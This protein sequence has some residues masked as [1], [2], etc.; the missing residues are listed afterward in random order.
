[1]F[2]THKNRRHVRG[3]RDT[4]RKQGVWVS[5][6]ENLTIAQALVNTLNEKEP[7]QWMDGDQRPVSPALPSRQ[8]Q[9]TTIQ[10]RTDFGREIGNLAKMYQDENK[11]SGSSDSFKYKVVIF[12][13]CCARVSIPDEA[14]AKAFPTMLKDMA[15]DYFYSTLFPNKNL[16]FHQ[17]CEGMYEYFEGKQHT[18]DSL[19]RW[20]AL[21]LPSVIS[22]N[23][24][25][26]IEEC[27]QILL[28]ELR[29]LQRSLDPSMQVDPFIHNKLVTACETLPA[30]FIVCFRPPP[31]VAELVGELKS[32][33]ITYNKS[34]PTKNETFFTDRRFHKF[35]D[36]KR[37]NY[38]THG[39]NTKKCYVCGKEGCFSTKHSREDQEESKKQW[40]ERWKERS[41]K[42][43]DQY[44]TEYEGLDEKED[45]GLDEAMKGLTFD[46]SDGDH[47]SFITTFGN[48][49][50]PKELTQTLANNSFEHFL[51]GAI[52]NTQD[53][54]KEDF[55]TP[56]VTVQSY[57]MKNSQ[58][59][60][61]V[62]LQTSSVTVQRYCATDRYNPSR[63]HGIVIDT[64]ASRFSTAGK[65]QY[66]AYKATFL[67]KEDI[68]YSKAG[69]AQ[70]KFGIGS[71]PS[72][73]SI[74]IRTP[75]GTIEFHVVEADTPFL[76]C[77]D[78]M[79]KLGVY[80]NNVK[81]ELVAQTKTI[82][83]ILR[84]GHPF[85]LWEEGLQSFL[86]DS[87]SYST[88][89]LTETELR[90][91][92]RRF[93]HPSA[94]RLLQLLK[95]SG[96]DDE[97]SNNSITKLTK[98]CAHCQ[99][100]GKSP[101]RFKFT[102]REDVQFNYSII[103]DVMYIE[104]DPVLHI[105]DEGTRFQAARWL[106]NISAKHTWE[107]LRLCWID[108]YIGPP[109]FIVHDAGKN[110]ISKEFRQYAST[111]AVTTK[112]V[113]VEAHWSIGTVERYHKVI[114][115]AYAIISKELNVETKFEKELALQ[116]AVKAVNDTAGP[117]GLVPT[118]LVFGAFP[119]MT[120]NSAPTPTT[121]QRAIAIE[122]ALKEVR[123]CHAESQVQS[124]L[125]QRNGPSVTSVHD[126]PLNSDVLVWREGNNSSGS[127]TGPFKLLSI[128]N[129]TC[130]VQLPNG[131]I[132]FRTTTVKP[133]YEDPEDP[134]DSSRAGLGNTLDDGIDKPDE[135]QPLAISPAE[136]VKRKRGRPRKV[137]PDVSVMLQDEDLVPYTNSRQKEINGLLEKGCF[138]IVAREDIPSGIRIFN[139]RFVDSIKNE[140]TEQAFEKSRLVVQAY[141]DQE[142]N[143]VLTQSPTIQRMSQRIILALTPMLQYYKKAELYLR[144][145]SQAYVQ[146]T[147]LLNR[148]FFVRPPAELK[149]QEGSVLNIVKPLYGVPEA[150]NHWFKTYH[151]HHTEKLD[152][153]QST[154]DP[155]LLTSKN[156]VGIIGLQT[157][158]TLILAD[159]DF[160]IAEEI[161]LNKAGF[162]AKE[163]QQLE[164][165]TPVK[166]NGGTVTYEPF[167]KGVTQDTLKSNSKAL[168]V[169]DKRYCGSKIQ[170][171]G[172]VVQ[173]DFKDTS[174]TI[175]RY[176]RSISLTQDKL[177]KNLD[178]VQMTVTNLTS[179]RGTVRKS[180]NKKDQYVAQRARGAYIA[181]V[182]QPEAA[183]DLSFAAQVIDPK[184]EDCKRLNKRLQ[185]QIDN[186]SRGLKFVRLDI[187]TLRLIVF[188]DASF[189]NNADASSQIGFVIVLADEQN[190]ANIIHWSS[191]KCKR[192]TRSVLAS[193]LY[194]TAHG[195]DT[196]IVIKTTLEKIINKP[197][198]LIL[199]TD[200]KSLY[201]C[202]VKLGSTQEKRLMIDLMCLRQ[203]YERRQITEV[204]WISG[205][206]NP[207]DAMTKGKKPCQA[208]TDLIDT[209]KVN[210]S[211]TG[212]VEREG[213]GS[214]E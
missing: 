185:W 111:M 165:D 155:C 175:E 195:F 199:C 42:R 174:V 73:G 36:Q 198:P 43:F 21:T 14:K 54:P 124:A 46:D 147:T 204:K 5:T 7:S 162:Q 211:I 119:R 25:K 189:A 193:E 104:G 140:G 35:P 59:S 72:I 1:M 143:L 32:A 116:I 15:L 137:R 196:G 19:A 86:Q 202:L 45:S 91:L 167:S 97:T 65:G 157:D 57:C 184:D 90:Q 17:M 66:E 70:V 135:N 50:N 58:D 150:G 53:S 110:F 112:A 118:L 113:P 101:G 173:C 129:E 138:E 192:V 85:L 186:H 181:S 11:Y 78:D 172:D 205:D 8:A 131:V 132:D 82:P 69:I 109:D 178:T 96:H 41:A 160:A 171:T 4:L 47:A 2:T 149:L 180:V 60:F 182:C 152:M 146:S 158:D 38:Q 115:R 134:L 93:G 156:G 191:I 108:T 27:F 103:V 3:L 81:N 194:A 170:N 20:N 200:S 210:L 49:D 24:D 161:Q 44:L 177:C 166:F 120:I 68:D 203:S 88:S 98:F 51:T 30:C 208:L 121:A 188:T 100:H 56:S 31:T 79:N 92:H 179:S 83:V 106:A 176:G 64:G 13:E 77:L 28:K 142:K 67:T 26:P 23:E 141:N 139:S 151:N 61:L 183:F 75:V 37:T 9:L 33:I 206:T 71:T 148:E 12:H 144:D 74:T 80:Y 169:T 164:A 197:I 18:Q 214:E 122:K 145:I 63:F 187:D 55:M 127:W 16:G 126:L 52:A 40:R 114:R 123:K 107:T 130:K 105:V 87:T 136:P 128:E 76:L 212:W 95:R 154:Y 48:I 207:A 125:N 62:N 190:N 10:P 22:K 29:Q 213:N 89:Y 39:R 34:H 117:N 94:A 209:N 153:L 159:E 6:D 201:D 84:F 163:R 168:S 133:F 102:L 99:K